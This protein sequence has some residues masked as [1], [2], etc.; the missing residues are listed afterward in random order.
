MMLFIII[1]QFILY[2]SLAILMG[3][4]IL[5]LIPENLRPS[6]AIS[7]KWLYTSS[8]VIPFVAFVPNIQLISILAPQFGFI[9]SLWKIVSKYK[10]GHAWIAIMILSGLLLLVIYTLIKSNKKL[11][12]VIAIFLLTAIMFAMA[13]VSH[14]SS[15]S[16]IAGVA[17]DFIHLFSVSIWLGILLIIAFFTTNSNNWEAFLKWFSPTALVAFTAIAL[18]G[19][20][21][22]EAV[23]PAYV[24]GWASKYGQ[25]LFIKH[26]LLLPLTFILLANAILIKLKIDKPLFE[27]RTWVKIEAGL[28][29]G[30]LAI[31]AIFS[32]QQPPMPFV[33]TENLSAVFQLFNTST[34]E[35]GMTAH[36]Q[37]TGIGL[38]FFL[39]TVVFIVLLVL[40]YIKEA[41]VSIAIAM[42]VA[43]ALCFY[44]GF[45]S[46][47]M[48]DFIGYCIP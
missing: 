16:A 47:T 36:F 31:T 27:P 11:Y 33:Q 12:A 4:F 35:S 22:T 6:F 14:A 2:A 20:L 32:E 18:S 8:T 45:N 43:V 13:Y 5:Q 3:T 39:L 15:M 1:S 17:F 38:M 9:D 46:I 29:I 37:M 25:W 48:V 23:V 21:L 44:M 19:V 34:L 10:V 42:A 41:P 28:L 24:T 7:N 40:S 26:V 30:I